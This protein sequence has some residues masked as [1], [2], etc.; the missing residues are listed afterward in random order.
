MATLLLDENVAIAAARF[1]DTLGHDAV[2]AR[3]QN[4]M[5]APDYELLLNAAN[6]G[7]IF[8]THNASDPQLLHGAWLRWTQSWG[9]QVQHSGILIIEQRLQLDARGIGNVVD[10]F[11]DHHTALSNRLYRLSPQGWR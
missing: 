8:V 3:D 4:A 2:T 11:I 7:R 1:L 5:N 6:E 10:Q 9:V